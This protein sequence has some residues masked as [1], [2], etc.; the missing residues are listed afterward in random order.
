MNLKN[1]NDAQ[2]TICN[3]CYQTLNILKNSL[4]K[5]LTQKSNNKG[6][7]PSFYD[8]FK[9]NYVENIFCLIALRYDD[10]R[11][12]ALDEHSSSKYVKKSKKIKKDLGANRL[13]CKII[14]CGDN[15]VNR[16]T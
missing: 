4:Y 8:F 15:I 10:R 12:N 2:D 13:Y 7:F 6:R 9:L 16:M 14:N 11:T 1:L 5:N 3:K